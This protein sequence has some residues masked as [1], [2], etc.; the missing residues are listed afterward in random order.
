M[1][2]QLSKSRLKKKIR[3]KVII[4][5][6]ASSGIGRVIATELANY[7]PK[8]VI[9]ARRAKKLL[10]TSRLLKEKGIEFIPIVGDVRNNEDLEKIIEATLQKFGTI[11]ILVNNA[12]LGKVNLFVNQT[13]EDIDQLID[14]NIKAL[15]K[16]TR[17]TLPIMK[18]NGE[19]HIVNISSSIFLFPSYPFAVYS[20]TK[21]AVKVFSDCI[22]EEVK[23]YGIEIS[24]VLPGP[25]NT[26]FNQVAGIDP[27][28]MPGFDVN[29]LSQRIVRLIANPKHTIIQ[30]WFYRILI[31]LS[32]LFPG[33]QK[34]L[35]SHIS[36]LAI[37]GIPQNAQLL[38]NKPDII[39]RRIKEKEVDVPSQ[40]IN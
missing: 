28:Y 26:E 31:V 34:T 15:I 23:N 2:F 10:E 16:L 5:T 40:Q 12:G 19:G 13:E 11:D 33:I 17:K 27:K 4:I 7:N 6:G 18:E 39:D 32:N 36:K 8:L 30:P 20:A 37:R 24:T 21:A 1:I 38:I 14:T 25:Y 3:G 35:G 22:R 9:I 29:K